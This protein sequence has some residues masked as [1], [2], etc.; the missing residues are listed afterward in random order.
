MKGQVV[1]MRLLQIAQE[2]R[3]NEPQQHEEDEKR[4]R[5]L[6]VALA[7][8]RDRHSNCIEV[9]DESRCEMILP[10]F[11]HVGTRDPTYSGTNKGR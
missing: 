9:G 6:V 7:L 4:R 3:Y 2:S 11:L 1:R 8:L 10:H 5:P